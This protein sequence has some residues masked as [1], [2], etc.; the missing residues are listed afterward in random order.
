VTTPPG[1]FELSGLEEQRHAAVDDVVV[2]RSRRIADLG[3]AAECEF[4]V[5]APAMDEQE[6]EDWRI[7]LAVPA[8]DDTVRSER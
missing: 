6:V 8:T 2:G 1:N 4:E 5:P 7:A 3:R